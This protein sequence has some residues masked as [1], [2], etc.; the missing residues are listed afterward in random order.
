MNFRILLRSLK[1]CNTCVLLLLLKLLTRLLGPPQ[2][3]LKLLD[4]QSC[5]L[6]FLLQTRDCKLVVTRDVLVLGR[7]RWPDYLWSGESCWLLS[8]HHS[9]S[10][11][12]VFRQIK[13]NNAQ[14]T[15]VDAGH[16]R[17]FVLLD[18]VTFV[19]FA[20]FTNF[21]NLRRRGRK[22]SLFLEFLKTELRL[23]LYVLRIL[24]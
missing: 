3:C 9:F 12:Q 19:F 21:A 11:C 6:F 5:L 23:S 17:H 16:S 20:T 2:P 22:S 15:A 13:G 10:L 8:F 7:Q 14:G 18:K 1:L 4:Y 24:N